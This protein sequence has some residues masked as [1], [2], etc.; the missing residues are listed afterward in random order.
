MTRQTLRQI[1]AR[2]SEMIF[3]LLDWPALTTPGSLTI[4]TGLLVLFIAFRFSD[5][6][7]IQ[8]DRQ[9]RARDTP[10]QANLMR[11]HSLKQIS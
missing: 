9:Q 10:H 1:S 7:T 11:C 3:N 5:Y 8:F 2:S 4:Y 6:A